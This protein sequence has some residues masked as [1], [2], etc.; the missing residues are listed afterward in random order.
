MQHSCSQVKLYLY[1]PIV[2][3]IEA[4]HS[5][6]KGVYSESLPLIDV[7][8]NKVLYPPETRSNYS[9]FINAKKKDI[10]RFFERDTKKTLARDDILENATIFS[11][12]LVLSMKN[13][14]S[15]KEIYKSMI[16]GTRSNI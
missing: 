11:G 8:L 4:L 3:F 12:R 10:E 5:S 1:D 2:T 15:S 9:E 14:N 6:I 16:Y 13:K 7:N